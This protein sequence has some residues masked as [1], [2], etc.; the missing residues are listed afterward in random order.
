MKK[1]LRRAAVAICMLLPPTTLP[2]A[3]ATVSPQ[4]NP[5][6]EDNELPGSA[7]TEEECEVGEDKN[8]E[9]VNNTTDEGEGGDNPSPE[10]ARKIMEEERERIRNSPGWLIPPRPTPTVPPSSKRQDLK[11]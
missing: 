8:C 2:S 3:Y 10:E 7:D 5:R 9:E 1:T 11:K 4:Q 6:V